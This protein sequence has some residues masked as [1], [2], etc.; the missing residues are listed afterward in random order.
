MG[1]RRDGTLA[2]PGGHWARGERLTTAVLREAYE[3]TRAEL[4]D[5]RLAS[6]H[7]VFDA[8]AGAWK[9][10][11]GFEAVAQDASAIGVGDGGLKELRWITVEKVLSKSS[12]LS[13]FASDREFLA[14]VVSD[15]PIY[16]RS[17]DPR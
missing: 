9:V 8:G 1:L 11:I 14:K 12:R 4:V 15:M 10:S 13:L 3:E 16:T 17:I 2:F 7:E 5:L 6:I